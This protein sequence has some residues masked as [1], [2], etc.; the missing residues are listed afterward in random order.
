ML[1]HVQSTHGSTRLLMA[2]EHLVKIISETLRFN[3]C[4]SREFNGGI[5]GNRE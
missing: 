5:N 2:L 1:Q 3:G 4:D